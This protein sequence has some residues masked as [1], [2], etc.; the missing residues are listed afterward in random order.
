M[1]LFI[2]VSFSNLLFNSLNIACFCRVP[3]CLKHLLKRALVIIVLRH[4]SLNIFVSS[5]LSI[6]TIQGYEFLDDVSVL[7]EDG[8]MQDI[9][10]LL[11]C[12]R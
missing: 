7:L 10:T 4:F 8:M 5:Q 1:S 9:F 11:I 2:Y 12:E 6:I 3:H